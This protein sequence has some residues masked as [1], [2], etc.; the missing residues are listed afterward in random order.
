MDGYDKTKSSLQN[1]IENSLINEFYNE[2]YEKV[3]EK[4]K[5]SDEAMEFKS[6]LNSIKTKI[7]V[8][9]D[10]IFDFNINTLSIVE[11][12]EYLRENKKAKKEF[13]L[14]ILSS[15]IILSTYVI[16]IIKI[17][18]KILIISQIIIVIIIPWIGIVY[19]VIKRRGSEV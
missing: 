3:D 5:C 19:M 1:K 17:G 4:L 15:F 10:D 9:N 12:G 14:F 11:K 18:P 6:E 13:I 7:S 16:T 8:L 2:E